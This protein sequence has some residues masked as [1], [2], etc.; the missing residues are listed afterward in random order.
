MLKK[1]ITPFLVILLFFV[2][3]PLGNAAGELPGIPEVGPGVCAWKQ[4]NGQPC[5]ERIQRCD[6]G[7]PPLRSRPSVSSQP[8]WQPSVSESDRVSDSSRC[9][10]A[11][12]SCTSTCAFSSEGQQKCM[13]R[14][15]AGKIGN[16]KQLI[17]CLQSMSIYVDS[18]SSD[19]SRSSSR[20]ETESGVDINK[21]SKELSSHLQL[22]NNIFLSETGRN[23]FVTSAHREWNPGDR[24]SYHQT[25]DAV[26]LRIRHLKLREQIAVYKKLKARLGNDYDVCLELQDITE[27]RGI[28]GKS[29]CLIGNRDPH[30]HVEYDRNRVTR[31]QK[32]EVPPP[33]VTNYEAPIEEKEITN[34][35]LVQ[36]LEEAFGHKTILYDQTLQVPEGLDVRVTTSEMDV[37]VWGA[38]IVGTGIAL[39]IAKYTLPESVFKDILKG[40]ARTKRG[41]KPLQQ[42]WEVISPVYEISQVK[43]KVSG[44]YAVGPFTVELR[45]LPELMPEHYTNKNLGLFHVI[46]E[47]Q[48]TKIKRIQDTVV[49]PV[50]RLIFGQTEEFSMFFV[51]II[52][53]AAEDVSTIT[54][55]ATSRARNVPLTTKKKKK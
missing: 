29:A 23:A 34:P 43:P 21:L 33:I 7:C 1:R 20:L 27:A 19:E 30:I 32:G 5:D 45:Y 11:A 22:M 26:D 50:K 36:T 13:V 54:G 24:F 53:E 40:I 38:K 10:S 12:S 28:L 52:P 42:D 17:Q 48:K 46:V 44:D 35:T 49:D 37:A 2:L 51:G 31:M 15:M 14:C 47:G 3:F 4:P 55:S 25:G 41:V 39:R 9:S 18:I 6:Q 8:S 16:R